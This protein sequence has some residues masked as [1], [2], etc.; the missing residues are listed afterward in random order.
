MKIAKSIIDNSKSYTYSEKLGN[1]TFKTVYKIPASNQ[2]VAFYF[3]TEDIKDMG[4][5][6]SRLE[7]IVGLY[8]EKIFTPEQQRYW[9]RFFCWPT[10]LVEND[11]GQLGLI[12]PLY[13]KNFFFSHNNPNVKRP[14][15]KGKEKNGGWF[16]IAKHRYVTL[17]KE[18]RPNWLSMIQ[19]C[20]RL[21][22]AIRKMHSTGLCHS[23]LSYNNV[24]VDPQMGGVKIIDVDGLVVP[25]RYDQMVAGTDSFIA[26]EIIKTAH[27]NQNDSKKITHSIYTDR[28]SLGVLIYKFLFHRDPIRDGCLVPPGRDTQDEEF[29]LSGEYALFVEDSNNNSNRIKPNH[30]QFEKLRAIPEAI[31]W[32]DTVKLPYTITGPYLSNEIKKCFEEGLH[33]PTK[34]PTPSHWENA[35]IKTTDLLL[36]C[37]NSNCSE[38]WFV[39]CKQNTSN[40]N[41]ICPFCNKIYDHPIVTME[42]MEEQSAGKISAINHKLM[43]YHNQ[44][45]YPWHVFKGIIPNENLKN[46]EQIRIGYFQFH[47]REWYFTNESLGNMK[48]INP[49]N[50]IGEKIP[51]GSHIEVNDSTRIIFGDLGISRIGVIQIKK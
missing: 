8:R 28:F 5:H 47:H 9:K 31:K 36:P 30:K 25:G 42:F 20:T 50:S 14:K 13:E 7:S 33:N 49:D 24:I 17:P 51:K 37:R 3:N 41:M 21:S 29:L 48:L 6:K 18:E 45:L 40:G 44:I 23:D 10:D 15:L 38:E 12:M 2:V 35:F 22:R 19:I 27:L 39:A 11:D 43:V 4:S 34:R 1:G 46:N 16:A 32:K 26:P